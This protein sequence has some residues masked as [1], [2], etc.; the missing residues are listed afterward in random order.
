MMEKRA[1]FRELLGT[2]VRKVAK[3]L[4][5]VRR[6]RSELVEQGLEKVLQGKK[7]RAKSQKQS[8]WNPFNRKA[9]NSRE[10]RKL[11][12]KGDMEVAKASSLGAE[13]RAIEKALQKEREATSTAR[14][15]AV[16]GVAV[17]GTGGLVGKH[18]IDKKKEADTQKRNNQIAMVAMASRA[19]HM[20]RNGANGSGGGMNKAMLAAAAHNTNMRNAQ[21]VQNTQQVPK[22]IPRVGP[23]QGQGA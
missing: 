14:K 21:R 10:G 4:R 15:Q 3:N 11:I 1:F 22:M 12:R 16:G 9:E 5:N 8:R 23:Q 18:V 20:R 17:L 13:E 7:L 2:N 19:A 6:D